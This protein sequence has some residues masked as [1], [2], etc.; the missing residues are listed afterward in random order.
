MGMPVTIFQ[1]EAGF[2][3]VHIPMP[4]G[5]E[6]RTVIDTWLI[7][8]NVTNDSKAVRAIG[9]TATNTSGGQIIE[10]QPPIAN[11]DL[12]RSL[13]RFLLAEGVEPRIGMVTL[14]NDQAGT[15]PPD[16]IIENIMRQPQSP[17]QPAAVG[18]ES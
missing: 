4:F 11:R 3:T 8:E 9:G 1:H 2:D 10:L 15:K 16:R 6:L 12:V 14:V 18:E 5:G 13:A 7:N 17:P